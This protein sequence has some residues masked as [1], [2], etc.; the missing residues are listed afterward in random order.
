MDKIAWDY[1][2]D[3]EKAQLLHCLPELKY[4]RR[5]QK[6]LDDKEAMEQASK[7]RRLND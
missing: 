5:T 2:T 1:L 4:D 7:I 3:L 6:E